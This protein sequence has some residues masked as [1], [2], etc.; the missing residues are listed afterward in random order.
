MREF[1]ESS[2]N[3]IDSV[4]FFFIMLIVKYFKK[5]KQIGMFKP[6][7]D[8]FFITLMMIEFAYF[9]TGEDSLHET[10]GKSF[11]VKVENGPA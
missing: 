2:R 1:G 5:L 4:C 9:D 7:I 11:Q 3:G 10:L 8:C 6:K